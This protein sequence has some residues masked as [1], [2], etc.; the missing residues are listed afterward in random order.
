[1]K[2]MMIMVIMMLTMMTKM[3]MRMKM[4]MMPL[5][6]MMMLMMILMVN[7][8]TQ[9]GWKRVV[10]GSKLNTLL[11]TQLNALNIPSVSLHWQ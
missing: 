4:M 5:M 11:S 7:M 9:D 1:M 6:M 3:A 8:S 10:L 2:M